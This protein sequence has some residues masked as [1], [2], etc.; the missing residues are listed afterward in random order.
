MK[1]EYDKVKLHATLLN[2]IF[3]KDEGDLG[4][5]LLIKERESFD[6]RQVLETW[7]S[8]SFGRVQLSEIHLSQRRAGRRTAAGYYLPSAVLSLYSC[9]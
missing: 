3:R 5:R 6:A 4:D 8:F 7:G 2:T 9:Q 1:R